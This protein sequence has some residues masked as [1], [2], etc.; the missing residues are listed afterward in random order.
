MG[1]DTA[2]RVVDGSVI[3]PHYHHYIMENGVS[4]IIEL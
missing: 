4:T 2:R 1:S 3:V